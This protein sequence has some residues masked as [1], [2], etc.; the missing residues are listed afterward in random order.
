M[1]AARSWFPALLFLAAVPSFAQNG[2]VPAAELPKNPKALLAIGRDGRVH[3]LKVES[4]PYPSLVEAAMRAVL[5]WEYKPYLLN[6]EPV[7]V[8]T[9][10][11]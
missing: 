8:E 10:I 9:T 3:D 4:A 5:H 2:T 6:G 7:E 11:R 1:R